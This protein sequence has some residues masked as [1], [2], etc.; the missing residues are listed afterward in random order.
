MLVTKSRP[1]ANAGGLKRYSGAGIFSSIGRKIFSSGLKKA[2]SSDI[3]SDLA[4]KVADAVV[5]GAQRGLAYAT[6]GQLVTEK[7]LRKR[8]TANNNS[9]NN[10]SSTT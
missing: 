10:F 1:G 4:Q 7:L 5:S 9:N 3:S 2:I 6:S 8:P